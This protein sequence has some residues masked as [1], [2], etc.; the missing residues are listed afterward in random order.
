MLKGSVYLAKPFDNPFGSL[1]A[2][3][4][5]VEDEATGIIAK[6]AGKVKPDPATG[7]LTTTFAENPQLPLED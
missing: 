2:L 6:L 1:L 7:Q 5:V 3:Y 4:L